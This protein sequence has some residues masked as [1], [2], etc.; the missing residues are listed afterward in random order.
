[1]A[2]VKRFRELVFRFGTFFTRHSHRSDDRHSIPFG[3]QITDSNFQVLR[4][5]KM[6]DRFSHYRM[7]C[8]T[9]VFFCKELVLFLIFIVKSYSSRAT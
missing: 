9:S 1:M 8:P 3:L 2:T 5:G 4:R 7:T 6:G